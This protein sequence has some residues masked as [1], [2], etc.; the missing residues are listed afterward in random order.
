M[1]K[2]T[3]GIGKLNILASVLAYLIAV[4]VLVMYIIL[5]TGN[6]PDTIAFEIVSDNWVNWVYRFILVV[7]MYVCELVN[8]VAIPVYLVFKAKKIKPAEKKILAIAQVAA[9]FVM[10]LLVILFWTSFGVLYK[11][12]MNSPFATPYR[13][14]EVIFVPIMAGLQLFNILYAPSDD[15]MKQLKKQRNKI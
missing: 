10:L 6:K 4:Y 13:I 11:G 9:S 1:E 15:I 8:L 5:M 7:L 3:L 2:K 14:L 12:D